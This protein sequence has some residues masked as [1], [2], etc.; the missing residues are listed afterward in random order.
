MAYDHTFLSSQL[1]LKAGEIEAII[2][3]KIIASTKIAI[4]IQACATI[5]SNHT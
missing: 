1:F 5:C 4:V 3:L 2:I